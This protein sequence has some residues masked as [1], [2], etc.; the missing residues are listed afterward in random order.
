MNAMCAVFVGSI[1][2]RSKRRVWRLPAAVVAAA[3]TVAVVAVAACADDSLPAAAVRQRVP[4]TSIVTGGAYT[5][6]RGRSGDAIC[7]ATNVTIRATV[8]RSGMEGMIDVQLSDLVIDGEECTS[9]GVDGDSIAL[10]GCYGEALREEAPEDDV[11]GVLARQRDQDPTLVVF[12]SSYFLESGRWTM[13][14]REVVIAE[15]VGEDFILRIMGCVFV[16]SSRSASPRRSTPAIGGGGGL[17]PT[18]SP[19]PSPEIPRNGAAV[20]GTALTTGGAYVLNRSR[21]TGACPATTITITD[22]GDVFDEMVYIPTDAI[23]MD[24]LSCTKPPIE[25][26]G[27]WGE[28]LKEEAFNKPAVLDWQRREPSLVYVDVLGEL[29]CGRTRFTHSDSLQFGILDGQRVLRVRGCLYVHEGMRSSSEARSFSVDDNAECFP[30]DAVVQLASGDHRRMDALRV[31]DVVRTGGGGEDGSSDGVAASPIYGFSH[32]DPSGMGA[33]VSLVTAVGSLRLTA[34]HYVPVAQTG[35][36]GRRAGSADRCNAAA[37][38]LV[39][40]AAVTVG[41]ALLH[42]PP[43]TDEVAT[44][45]CSAVSAANISDDGMWTPVTAVRVA[46]AAVAG[47]LYAPHTAPATVVVDGFLASVYTTAVAPAVAGAALAPIRAASAVGLGGIVGGKL[48]PVLG[49]WSPPAFLA[50]RTA[51]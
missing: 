47:G 43:A 16:H 5:L 19:S 8:H 25:L 44:T 39:A 11:S 24:G 3:T 49:G 26:L 21:S 13:P 15:R 18:A 12:W 30:A 1:Y 9:F 34:G 46:T 29:R 35:C 17:M 36:A 48:L 7:I 14:S 6:D 31:G 10:Q 45:N 51:Y 23:V 28:A 40:A 22:I 20:A 27:C 41:D 4:G 33:Y 2:R 37:A 42:L 38:R 50:G 32:A